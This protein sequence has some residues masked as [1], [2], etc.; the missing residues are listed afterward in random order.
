MR[1]RFWRQEGLEDGGE[2]VG[3][4]VWESEVDARKVDAE[5]VRAEEWQ[6]PGVGCNLSVAG[7]QKMLGQ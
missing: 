7:L 6:I 1:D 4:K 2:I 5:I 3:T